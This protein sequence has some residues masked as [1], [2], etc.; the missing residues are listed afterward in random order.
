M[1]GLGQ[2]RRFAG[3]EHLGQTGSKADYSF[4]AVARAINGRAA[5]RTIATVRA[6]RMVGLFVANSSLGA[7]KFA[8]LSA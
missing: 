4:G 8:L 1:P 3:G 7:L 2:R 6:E 5:K